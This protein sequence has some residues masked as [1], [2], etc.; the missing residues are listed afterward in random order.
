[1]ESTTVA[2]P[3]LRQASVKWHSVGVSAVSEPTGVES[4]GVNPAG[5]VAPGQQFISGYSSHFQNAY[6]TG[7]AGTSFS[8]GQSMTIGVIGALRR[9][10]DIPETVSV[11][12]SGVQ[13]GSFADTELSAKV[14]FGLRLNPNWSVGVALGGYNHAISSE[15]GSQWTFDLG[16]QYV[17]NGFKLGVSVQNVNQGAV[18]WT[19]GHS[20]QTTMEINA[21]ISKDWGGITTMV[22]ASQENSDIAC[23]IGAIIEV[24]EHLVIMGGVQDVFDQWSG[25]VGINL[26]LDTT[27]LLYSYGQSTDL[28]ETHK[29]GVEFAL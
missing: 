21:G 9:I 5:L 1:L 8:L 14:G 2:G 15:T 27:S 16:T 24:W 7:I 10:D 4:M 12:S 3:L 22:S 17:I 23:N 26:S 20:D 13:V 19:T 11:G 29:I 18:Q 6:T 28:G 25:G